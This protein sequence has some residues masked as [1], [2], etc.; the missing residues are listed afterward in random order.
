MTSLLMLIPLALVIAVIPFI[1]SSDYVLRI[2]A[3]VWIMSLGAIGLHIRHTSIT[4]KGRRGQAGRRGY[5]VRLAI[6]HP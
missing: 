5:V 6:E 1:T 3:L 2:A 4:A